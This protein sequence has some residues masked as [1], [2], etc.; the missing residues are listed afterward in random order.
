MRRGN[1]W[2]NAEQKLLLQACLL[3]GSEAQKSWKIWLRRID[4]ETLEPAS[5]RLLPLAY[6]NPSIQKLKGP[7][8]DRCRGCYRKT[9]LENQ[10][11]W[12]GVRSSLDL[13]T[14]HGVQVVLLK[15]IAMILAHYQDLG[16]RPIG[17]IDV[18]VRIEDLPTVQEIFRKNGMRSSD[19][20]LDLQ[21]K[22]Q[23][24]RWHAISFWDKEGRDI[25]LHWYFIHE[26]S[27]ALDQAVMR[28]KIPFESYFIPSPTHLF[29]QTCIHGSK[30]SP[31]PLIRWVADAMTLLRRSLIEWDALIDLAK[32]AHIAYPMAHALEYLV[33]EFNAPIPDAA[34]SSLRS[35]PVHRLI[36]SEHK[37][38]SRGSTYLAG[39]HRFCINRQLWSEG[40]QALHIHKYLQITAR[41]KSAWMIPFFAILWIFRRIGRCA[42]LLASK[43]IG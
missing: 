34:L 40:R 37:A 32:E 4:I 9:W 21:N 27:L 16:A 8:L 19:P 28:H 3:S 5:L 11:N 38:H 26:Q 35:L 24:S 36:I 18:L 15:G 20:R 22:E 6:R 42:T 14:E 1:C 25:D 31:I 7:I 30:F 17:D 23:L 10:L 43:N 41:L 2:P 12:K 39:W 33:E 29:L 13:L